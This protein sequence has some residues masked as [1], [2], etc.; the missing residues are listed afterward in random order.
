MDLGLRQRLFWPCTS[1]SAALVGVGS[2]VVW[3][4][5]GW[6]RNLQGGLFGE[7]KS[8]VKT[9]S[10]SDW[11]NRML[12][13]LCHQLM[14]GH[15]GFFTLRCHTKLNACMLTFLA[16]QTTCVNIKLHSSS[17]PSF[18]G[19]ITVE[20]PTDAHRNPHI[21]ISCDLCLPNPFFVPGIWPDRSYVQ[22]A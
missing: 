4:G 3:S 12:T 16:G 10:C 7:R 17:F 18:E 2:G 13:R 5:C 8:D 19:L 20:H 9:R 6:R 21:R 14:A 22:L 11:S 1:I 15:Q